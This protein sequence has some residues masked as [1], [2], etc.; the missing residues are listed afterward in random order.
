M[1]KGHQA[2]PEVR[3]MSDG[4]AADTG[5]ET[6]GTLVA[7]INGRL[8]D[9]PPVASLCK[10]PRRRRDEAREMPLQA[11]RRGGWGRGIAEL[12]ERNP[13]QGET[14]GRRA[15]LGRAWHDGYMD[16]ARGVRLD[17]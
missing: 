14:E 10:R 16:G 9:V 4:M 3:R 13:W 6:A 15:E 8:M 1:G 11:A 2:G 7:R 12:E 17:G 5:A